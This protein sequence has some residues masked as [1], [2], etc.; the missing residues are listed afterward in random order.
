M[1]AT[2]CELPTLLV[3]TGAPF[4][5]LHSPPPLPTCPMRCTLA[6]ACR[7]HW[8]FQS[9]QQGE[10]EGGGGAWLGEVGS[11]AHW[12][13]QSLWKAG[14]VNRTHAG[15]GEAAS[16]HVPPNIRSTIRAPS[17]SHA[18]TSTHPPPPPTHTCHTPHLSDRP[19]S[20]PTAGSHPASH[21]HAPHPTPV[22]QHQRVC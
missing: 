10:E 7:S 11:G 8:G 18:S 15:R 2:V 9:L 22:K 16:P 6:M 4:P 3:C 14:G 12:G 5:V 1:R 20:P 13:F 21:T 19:V 17:A